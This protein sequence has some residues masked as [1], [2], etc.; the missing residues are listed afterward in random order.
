MELLHSLLPHGPAGWDSLSHGQ[1][2]WDSLYHG[3]VGWDSLCHGQVGWD[4]LYHGQVGW[5]SP[6]LGWVGWDSLSHGPAGWDRLS[7]GQVGW[8]SLS[9]GQ[10][11]LGSLSHGQVGWDRHWLACGD[12]FNMMNVFLTLPFVYWCQTA[13]LEGQCPFHQKSIQSVNQLAFIYLAA[14][15]LNKMTCKHTSV[16]TCLKTLVDE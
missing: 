16:C 3:Q 5:D 7:H 6:S 14:K 1:V 10:V 11:G 13:M 12:D 2:G 8:D 9:G 15:Q 4:S